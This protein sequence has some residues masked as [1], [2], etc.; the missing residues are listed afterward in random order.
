MNELNKR[1]FLKYTLGG[2]AAATPIYSALATASEAEKL[3]QSKE[4]LASGKSVQY[5]F[6][7]SA[8]SITSDGDKLT[9]HGVNPSTLFFSDRPERIT[10]HGATEEWVKTWST[11]EDSFAANPPNAT[12]SILG[13]DEIEDVV[14]VLK[15]PQLSGSKLTYTVEVL[16]GT[17]PPSG[18]ASSLFIDVIGR[19]L[20]P[21]SVAGVARRT[22]R[23]TTRRVI[24]RNTLY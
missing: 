12:L 2:L 21:V 14:I 1:T 7:Q 16:D 15:D 10:G 19:P 24:R 3:P 13:G 11:G 5:L 9:L 4:T 18:G 22:S 20:T 8:H 17:L 6:V 23:R